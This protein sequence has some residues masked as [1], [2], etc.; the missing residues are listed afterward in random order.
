M[1]ERNVL[2]GISTFPDLD[3]PEFYC[4]GY[5]L[6]QDDY[7]MDDEQYEEKLKKETLAFFMVAT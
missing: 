2:R 1:L 3:L 4:V 6:D 7:A 5:N